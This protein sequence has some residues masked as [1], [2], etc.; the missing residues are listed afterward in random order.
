MVS[1]W[2]L[3]PADRPNFQSLEKMVSFLLTDL[4][5]YLPLVPELSDT[6]KS[7]D[8]PQLADYRMVKDIYK[9]NKV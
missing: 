8:I 5:D 4:K 2:A 7:N 9:E 6:K 1:C 3:E